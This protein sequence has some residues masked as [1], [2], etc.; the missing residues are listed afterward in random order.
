M[1]EQAADRGWEIHRS[2]CGGCTA[3]LRGTE[4]H[5]EFARR[6]VIARRTV[7]EFLGPLIEREGFLTTR[8]ER[9]DQNS[10]DFVGRLGFAPM[11]SDSDYTY[12]I[13]TELP[14]S[15]RSEQCPQQSHS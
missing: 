11:W 13:L 5:V 6:G 7:R 12:Y 4:I 1:I 10:S 9:D 2:R 8:V 14:F 15:K 3:A